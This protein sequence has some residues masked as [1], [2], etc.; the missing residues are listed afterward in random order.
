MFVAG[1]GVLLF[2]A[3][4][5]VS[6]AAVDIPKHA[7]D[8]WGGA[9]YGLMASYM[10]HSS[11]LFAFSGADG[12]TQEG[13]GFTGLLMPERYAV[14]LFVFNQGKNLQSHT[15]KLSIGDETVP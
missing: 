2:L 9:A 10:G 13:S 15:L 5:Q 7:P 14:S 1:S 4:L 6:R 11:H 12:V 3:C 8:V